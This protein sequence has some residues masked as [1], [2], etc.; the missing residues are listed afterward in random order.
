MANSKTIPL[1]RGLIVGETAPIY[2]QLEIS[3]TN[4]NNIKFILRRKPYS[5]QSDLKFSIPSP[6]LQSFIDVLH[7]AREKLD[8]IWFSRVA[9]TEL[10]AKK[11]N[12]VY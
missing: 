9:K 4:H 1:A 12:M 6:S 5:G 8:D 11:K 7:E 2:G 3:I 10:N